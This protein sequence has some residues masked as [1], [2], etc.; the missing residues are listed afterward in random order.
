MASLH[1]KKLT[2]AEYTALQ[3]KWAAEDKKFWENVR[4]QEI[5]RLKKHIAK[6]KNSYKT[7]KH[8]ITQTLIV[9]N[10]AKLK[11]LRSRS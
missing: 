1:G 7:N 11:T 5:E 3:R 8:P 9:K 6:L 2:K 4:T 10:E